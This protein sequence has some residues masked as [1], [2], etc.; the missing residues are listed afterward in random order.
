MMTKTQPEV[1]NKGVLFFAPGDPQSEADW[2]ALG[3][4]EV[5]KPL[6]ANGRIEIKIVDDEKKFLITGGKKP[7]PLTKSTRVRLRWQW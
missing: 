7:R 1:G 3:D 4:V 5:K 2:V 6:D